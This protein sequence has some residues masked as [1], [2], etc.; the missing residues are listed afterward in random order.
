MYIEQA[1]TQAEQIKPIDKVI[2]FVR[3]SFPMKATLKLVY[4]FGYEFELDSIEAYSNEDLN[5]QIRM[6]WNVEPNF[7]QN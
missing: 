2:D 7:I 6:Y 5:Q 4:P 1:L 3:D